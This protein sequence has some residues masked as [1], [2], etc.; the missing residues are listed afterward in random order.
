VGR[1]WFSKP[2]PH[3]Q[4]GG[5]ANDVA[6]NAQWF[7]HAQSYMDHDVEYIP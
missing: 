4:R 6:G 7:W 3:N 5:D 2:K 1:K